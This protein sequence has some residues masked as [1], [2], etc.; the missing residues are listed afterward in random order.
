MHLQI[1]AA[2]FQLSHGVLASLQFGKRHLEKN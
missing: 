2:I 1:Q